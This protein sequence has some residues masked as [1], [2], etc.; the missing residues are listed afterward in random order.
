MQSNQAELYAVQVSET[1]VVRLNES[2]GRSLNLSLIH[3]KNVHTMLSAN[4]SFVFLRRNYGHTLMG[5]RS[6]FSVCF[7]VVRK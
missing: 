5:A 3:L 2:Q 7:H 6:F 1:G 4:K